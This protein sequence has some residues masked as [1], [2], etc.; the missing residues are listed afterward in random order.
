MKKLLIIVVSLYMLWFGLTTFSSCDSVV[1]TVSTPGKDGN[2][3]YL[4]C[5]FDDSSQN[6]DSIILL[7]YSY[8]YDR[9]SLLQIPRDT[10]YRYKTSTKIN[11]IY[12]ILR[13]SG[14]EPDAAMQLMA[15]ELSRGLGVRID[16]YLGVTSKTIVKLI[17]EIGGLNIHLPHEVRV[18]DANGRLLLSLYEG[19]NLLNGNDV[20]LFLRSRNTYAMGDLA[21]VDAQKFF[22]SS[23]INKLKSEVS[24]KT[25]FSAFSVLYK[26]SVSDYEYDDIL[27][28]LMKKRGS[29]RE[30]DVNY[31]TIPGSAI[32]S[33]VGYWYYSICRESTIR[34]LRDMS[35]SILT[36]FDLDQK[37]KNSLDS[38][39]SAIYDSSEIDYRL[40][41]DEDLSDIVLN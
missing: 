34:L 24:V 18:E 4:V 12:P 25:L 8:L 11:S 30:I 22:L 7:N 23:L 32:Q 35:F 27:K 1:Q 19:D 36:D 6:T 39:F 29:L 15:A 31:A 17:D 38:G 40:Y 37:F 14:V 9:I 33:S 16:G 5:G 13:N 28:I 2:V 10:Y 3:T 20:V 21:R 41:R 26:N